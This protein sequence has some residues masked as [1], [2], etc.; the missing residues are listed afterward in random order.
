MK[1][2]SDKGTDPTLA[3][4]SQLFRK[5]CLAKTAKVVVSYLTLQ[6]IH[7]YDSITSK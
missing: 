1:S 7:R 4:Q 2:I 5:G 3:L 6:L